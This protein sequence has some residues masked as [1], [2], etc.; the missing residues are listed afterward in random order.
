MSGCFRTHLSQ[1]AKEKPNFAGHYRFVGWDGGSVC[2]AGALIDLRTGIVYPPPPRTTGKANGPERWIFTGGF[3]NGPFIDIR[4][5]SRLAIVRGQGR[6]PAFQ[7]SVTTSGPGRVF[8][9]C[10]R[11]SKRNESMRCRALNPDNVQENVTG[12]ADRIGPV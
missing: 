12:S 5:D 3:V 4:V 11:D 9:W 10:P 2:A 8:G 7:E 6:D 1:G